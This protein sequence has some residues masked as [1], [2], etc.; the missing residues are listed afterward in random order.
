MRQQAA[1]AAGG[2]AIAAVGACDQVAH[3]G[4]QDRLVPGRKRRQLPGRFGCR[5]GRRVGD[6]GL[7]G[8]GGGGRAA[9]RVVNAQEPG[10]RGDEDKRQGK[11][12]C[13][14]QPGPSGTSH[15]IANFRGEGH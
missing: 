12:Q 14:G 2:A 7:I 8:R 5:R 3:V 10:C 6:P 13:R 4:W 1:Q 11:D 15:S 9:I